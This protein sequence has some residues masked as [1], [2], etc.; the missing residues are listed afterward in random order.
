VDERHRSAVPASDQVKGVV[1]VVDDDYEG[2]D[3]LR[4]LLESHGY[5]VWTAG[6]GRE[7]LDR[8]RSGPRPCVVVLDLFMPVMNGWE[9]LRERSRDIRIARVPVIVVTGGQGGLGTVT[10]PLLRKPLNVLALLDEVD[11]VCGDAPSMS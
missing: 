1:M 9:F 3:A 7:A 10:E 5:V 11:R 8:L 6:N 2:T 4:F